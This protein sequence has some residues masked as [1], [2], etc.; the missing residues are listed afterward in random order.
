MEF[1]MLR[2]EFL[3]CAALSPLAIEAAPA[4]R[5]N[6]LFL[7]AD[8]FRF[9]ALSVMGNRIVTTPNLDRLAREG[10]LFRNAMSACP[11]CVPA[12]TAMLTGKTLANT[13]VVNNRASRDTE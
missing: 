9:D 11:V 10:G 2:R 4:S 3:Q 1:G 13:K 12:R 8:Q 6:L 5:F 7:M